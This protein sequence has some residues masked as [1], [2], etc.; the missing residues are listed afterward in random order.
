MCERR[1]SRKRPPRRVPEARE[2]AAAAAFARRNG[3][4]E[5]NCLFSEVFVRRLAESID[6]ETHYCAGDELVSSYPRKQLVFTARRME[7]ERV[8]FDTLEP[9]TWGSRDEAPVKLETGK[10]RGCCVLRVERSVIIVRKVF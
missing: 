6:E 5:E 2:R 1:C 9:D 8:L 4:A 10:V 3:N 7:E